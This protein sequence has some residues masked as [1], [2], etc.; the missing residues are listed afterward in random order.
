[1]VLATTSLRKSTC[2][3]ALLLTFA[4]MFTPATCDAS[5]SAFAALF[6]E[7]DADAEASRGRLGQVEIVAP[8][9][10]DFEDELP[11]QPLAQPFAVVLSANL[12]PGVDYTDWAMCYAVFAHNATASNSL[13]AAAGGGGGCGSG[14]VGGG[15]SD[16]ARTTAASVNA[17]WPRPTPAL[18]P[19]CVSFRVVGNSVQ[20]APLSEPIP[21]LFDGFSA[22]G[23]H[24]AVRVFR[25][26]RYSR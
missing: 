12:F 20:F 1:M 2:R 15:A 8:L 16:D 17:L 21:P 19:Y 24:M 26:I 10:A 13:L 18:P 3:M 5:F 9:A 22:A 25:L 7:L 6:V 11:P 14:G 4:T 23:P